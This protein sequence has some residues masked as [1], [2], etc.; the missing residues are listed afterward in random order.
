MDRLIDRAESELVVPPRAS[1]LIESMRDIGYTLE[2]AVADL[3]DNSIFALAKKVDIRFGWEDQNPWIAIIDN[4]K[5]LTSHGLIEAMRPGSKSPLENRDKKD[6]G[7]FGLGLKL[8][9]FSQ[10]R[11]LTVV[12]RRNNVTSSHCWDLDEVNKRNEWVLLKPEPDQIA[13]L[14]A[15]KHLGSEG[16][17][18]LWQKLD[19]LDLGSETDDAHSVLNDRISSISRH[20]SL[21]FHRFLAGESGL[22]KLIIS[23]NMSKLESFDPYN[24]KHP[25]AQQMSFEQL[26]IDGEIV[27]IQPFILPHHSKLTPDEYEYFGGEEG[28]LRNQGFYIYRNGRLIIHGTWFRMAKQEEITKLARVRVDI[29]NTLDHLW[30]IDV[31]KSKAHPPQIVKQRM[32]SIVK[33]IIESARRPYSHRGTVIEYKQT[34][35]VWQRKIKHGKISYEVNPKHPLISQFKSDLRASQY[36]NFDLILSLISKSFPAALLFNDAANSPEKIADSVPDEEVMNR[37]AKLMVESLRLTDAS[38]EEVHSILIQ[39]EPFA[40]HPDFVN[41]FMN[42][43]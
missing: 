28:Y 23:V 39:V 40:S 42:T 7:R 2:G 30:T 26:N 22:P 5:G 33:Q 9:S 1:A 12:S 21:V 29:P 20:L 18:V 31:R 11:K 38:Y 3:I 37:L 19:R 8:A 35:P 17:L 27:G 6:L 15:F 41:K 14:P 10:C 24:S 36:K 43:L 34:T 25:A 13:M 16:T 32:R 4:G